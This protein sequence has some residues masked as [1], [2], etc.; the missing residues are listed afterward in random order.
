MIKAEEMRFSEYEEQVRFIHWLNARLTTNGCFSVKGY[1]D[2]DI[3]IANCAIN[4]MTE[5]SCEPIIPMEFLTISNSEYSCRKTYQL[6]KAASKVIKDL[7]W[8]N[9]GYNTSDFNIYFNETTYTEE[10]RREIKK[11]YPDVDINPL[12][13]FHDDLFKKFGVPE[14]NLPN[15]DQWFTELANKHKHNLTD[16]ER[17]NH[18]I[19]LTKKEQNSDYIYKGEFHYPYKSL[20]KTNGW[21]ADIWYYYEHKRVLVKWD[22]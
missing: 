2:L 11:N 21:Y 3:D 14:I 13:N 7:G 9:G 22:W 5:Q 19:I 4:F 16:E 15:F 18:G 8:Y 12:L 1:V 20:L 10:E 6:N 17:N